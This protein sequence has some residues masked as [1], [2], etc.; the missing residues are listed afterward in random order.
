MFRG[1]VNTF[2]GDVQMR[3]CHVT[4]DERE[5]EDIRPLTPERAVD[6]VRHVQPYTYRIDQRKAAGVLAGDVPS[7]FTLGGNS[8]DYN[9]LFVHLWAAVQDLQARV[10]A[11]EKNAETPSLHL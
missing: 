4:S 7:E 11:L 8:V 1:T 3:R 5:K 6:L 2:N 10:D 9:S